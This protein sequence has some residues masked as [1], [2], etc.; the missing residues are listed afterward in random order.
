MGTRVQ[1]SLFSILSLV[2]PTPHLLMW[3]KNWGEGLGTVGLGLGSTY[4]AV[5]WHLLGLFLFCVLCRHQLP[6]EQSPRANVKSCLRKYSKA[7]AG[8]VC[9]NG[10]P[11]RG[12]WVGRQGDWQAIEARN[13]QRRG[14]SRPRGQCVC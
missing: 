9:K 3:K 14:W 7:K 4:I 8:S 5:T 12:S 13:R 11:R 10:H 6:R 2:L 1:G